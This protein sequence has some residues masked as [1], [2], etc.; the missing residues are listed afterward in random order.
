MVP[1]L[2]GS[3]LNHMTIITKVGASHSDHMN[4]DALEVDSFSLNVKFLSSPH[5]GGESL[6][7]RLFM[8]YM[9]NIC[10]CGFLV[11]RN[12]AMTTLMCV[13]YHVTG[14]LSVKALNT[15]CSVWFQLPAYQECVSA[16]QLSVVTIY[17]S[18]SI[19][20]VAHVYL[21]ASFPGHSQILSR[22]C[23]EDIRFSPQL[24]DKSWELHGNKAIY[25]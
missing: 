8:A 1:I 6:W 5:F 17:V 14:I 3:L 21:L 13:S 16:I 2:H 19:D 7:T 22:S 20:K 25:W 18:L 11:G 9:S 23:G 15:K 4:D 12:S 10:W 24:R